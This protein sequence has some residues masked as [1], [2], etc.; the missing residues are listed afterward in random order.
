MTYNGSPQDNTS[1]LLIPSE[2]KQKGKRPSVKIAVLDKDVFERK[3]SLQSLGVNP[4]YAQEKNAITLISY[5]LSLS[6]SLA[7]SL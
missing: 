7:Y 2:A 3:A 4:K 6:L 5:S 1:I